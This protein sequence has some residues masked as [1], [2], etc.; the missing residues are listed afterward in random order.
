MTME[1]QK[2]KG[3]QSG[4]VAILGRPNVGKS[5]LMNA[6]VGEK[7]AITSARAQTT[8]SRI[9]GVMTRE[10][11]QIVFL[12]TPGV[13]HPRNKLGEYMMSAVKDALDGV[14]AVIVMLDATD[15][16]PT[17]IE[18]IRKYDA[19]GVK[20]ALV[21]NKIDLVNSD[22]LAPLLDK[23]SVEKADAFIPISA[24]KKNGLDRLVKVLQGWMPEG[25]QYFP[26][27]MITD[28]P[29][30][31]IVAEMIRE[32]AL[33][34][35]RDEIPHGIGVEVLAMENQ[36]DERRAVTIHANIFCERDS[37]KGILIGKHG[38]MLRRIGEQARG[39]IEKML[40]QKVN[41]QLWVK[42]R[43]D[44]R[45]RADDL[46]TRCLFFHPRVLSPALLS[47]GGGGAP[48][49]PHPR[50][51]RSVSA[52]RRPAARPAKPGWQAARSAAGR[53]RRRRRRGR[54]AEPGFAQ[55]RIRNGSRP[56]FPRAPSPACQRSL[57]SRARGVLRRLSSGASCSSAL[58]MAYSA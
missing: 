28:Q 23:L 36:G 54:A 57:S 34:N 56:P 4:F 32:K 55:T 37:H 29:E 14:D 44:W 19:L 1:K 12:D 20:C 17:D 33:R 18:I 22:T 21:V 47:G 41:L 26:D 3:Y 40:G 42:V 39:D 16:R 53:R 15:V 38:D 48:P 25:P 58:S 7:V 8:R 24:Q 31:V 9:M 49:P 2:G 52:P 11:L 43:P 35:L 5:T 50:A 27:D 51:H 46:K 13:H 30:R 6:L 10:N 45:N